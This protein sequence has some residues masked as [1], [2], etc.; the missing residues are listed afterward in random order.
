MGK[1]DWKKAKISTI[2]NKLWSLIRLAVFKKY[3]NNCYTCPQRMLTGMNLQCGHAY[4]KGALG[5]SMKYDMRILRPQC[6]QC[7]IN[8][9]GMGAAFWK[10]LEWSMGKK[11][12]DKLYNECEASKGEGLSSTEVRKHY[13]KLMAELSPLPAVDPNRPLVVK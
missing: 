3:G 6:F 9:S 10:R 7:N 13:L 4:P 1:V 11:K 5:A 12:A 8:H 2:E